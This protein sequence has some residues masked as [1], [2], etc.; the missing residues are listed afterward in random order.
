MTQRE[1]ETDPKVERYT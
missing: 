1:V